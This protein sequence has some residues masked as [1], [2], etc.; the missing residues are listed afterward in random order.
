MSHLTPENLVLVLEARVSHN[1]R[2]S[3]SSIG[4]SE[5]L[6]YKWLATSKHAAKDQDVSSI[7]FMEHRGVWDYWHAHARRSRAEALIALD[8]T[9]IHQALHGIVVPLLDAQGRQLWAENPETVGKDDDVLDLEFGAGKWS[10]IMRDAQGRAVALTKTERLPGTVINKVLDQIPGYRGD[11]PSVHVHNNFN[12]SSIK[13]LQRP[14][15]PALPPPQETEMVR[16]LRALHKT[17]LANPNRPTSKPDPTLKPVEIMG[18]ATGDK[19]D[20]VSSFPQDVPP[21][22]DIRDHSRAY[23]AEP[24]LIP[25]EPVN[26]ARRLSSGGIDAAGMGRGPDP[27]LI[28]KSRGFRTA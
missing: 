1:W 28:G 9:I 12:S 8:S 7:F 10:R 25:A 3:M 16:E 21:T 23:T 6:A 14:A 11:A 24:T 20:Q 13:A 5:A 4:A 19:P 15:Q 26:Y 17:A 22:P 18:R 27:S 2:A